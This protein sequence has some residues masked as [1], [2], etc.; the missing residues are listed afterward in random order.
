M[1]IKIFEQEEKQIKNQAL[2]AI[3]KELL[4]TDE[5]IDLKNFQ[6]KY[7]HLLREKIDQIL[8]SFSFS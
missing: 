2:G 6:L 3:E 8:E 5:K 4:K 1:E 7:F